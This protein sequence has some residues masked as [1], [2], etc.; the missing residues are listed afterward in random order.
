M[1]YPKKLIDEVKERS[2]G[3]QLEGIN[4][5]SGPQHPLLMIVGEAPGRNE[6]VNN[7]PFSGDAGKELDKSLKQIGLTRDQVYITSAVRSRP[8]AIK[9]VFSKRENKEVQYL[10]N[11]FSNFLKG[12]NLKKIIEMDIRVK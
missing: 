10:F 11:L 8:F 6:I 4:S 1:D 5:G 12:K 2:K 9:K 3:M 7:I